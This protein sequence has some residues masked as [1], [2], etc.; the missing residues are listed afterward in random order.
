MVAIR[1]GLS[2]ELID[3]R[4]QDVVLG[5]GA[6]VR[7]EQEREHR[8]TSGRMVV[9]AEVEKLD[10]PIR[11]PSSRRSRNRRPVYFPMSQ[12]GHNRATGIKPAEGRR[13]L[14]SPPAGPG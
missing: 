14:T 4:N 7:C 6:H 1:A 3:L 10:G 11:R 5:T 13:A 2:L 8:C 9:I 12:D